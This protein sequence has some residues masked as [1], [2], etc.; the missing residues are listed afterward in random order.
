MT[1]IDP[2]VWLGGITPSLLILGFLEWKEDTTTTTTTTTTTMSNYDSIF[3]RE[4]Y[5]NKRIRGIINL[6]DEYVP[7]R[8]WQSKTRNHTHTTIIKWSG[9]EYLYLPTPDHFEPSVESLWTAV[10]FIQRFH[11]HPSIPNMEQSLDSI[12]SSTTTTTT[13]PT[14][15]VHCRA[16]HGRSAAVVLAW[17]AYQYWQNQQQQQQQEE[18]S[19][20]WTSW[21]STIMTKMKK[22]KK[23]KMT[24]T[25]TNLTFPQDLTNCTD[26]TICQEFD[27][28][29]LQRLNEELGRKRKVRSKLWLQPNVREF[30]RQ[31]VYKAQHGQ[32]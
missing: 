1:R 14:V 25:K 17:M 2:V 24:N 3:I 32:L 11:S 28:T 13:T 12:A 4:W 26:R 5:H 27:Y 31:L 6:C 8:M 30:Y 18:Q 19:S 23:K 21:V 16:G 15:Y 10:W 7:F 22:K 29:I 9:M 20:L